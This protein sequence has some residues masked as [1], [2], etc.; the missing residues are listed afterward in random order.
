MG[1]LDAQVGFRWN[2]REITIEGSTS[3]LGVI[4]DDCVFGYLGIGKGF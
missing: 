4:T 3:D 2:T 1:L